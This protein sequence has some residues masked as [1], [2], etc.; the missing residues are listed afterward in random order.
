MLLPD[1]DSSGEGWE[2]EKFEYEEEEAKTDKTPNEDENVTIVEYERS[3]D[4]REEYGLLDEKIPQEQ[5]IGLEEGLPKLRE[6]I[7]KSSKI[8][9]LSGAG[10]STE[11]GIPA[12]RGNASFGL[13]NIWE[14][15]NSDIVNI[16]TFL[17]DEASR[18]ALWQMKSELFDIVSKCSPNPSHL[19]P[20]ELHKAG[21]LLA[22]LTQ[23]IDGLYQRAGLPSEKVVELHGSTCQ[24][25]CMKCKKLSSMEET[26]DRVK[27]GEAVPLC[28][29]EGCGGL[30]KPAT[31][32]FGQ[33]LEEEVINAARRYL[34]ECDLLVIMGTSLKVAP[35]N[36]LPTLCFDRNVP[37]VILNKDETMYDAYASVVISDAACGE[38]VG[39]IG[40]V[41]S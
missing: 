36:K 24:T 15:Y 14:R 41:H 23:N 29:V 40:Q 9:F 12:Y 10:V 5:F 8:V 11:S 4:Q 37:V 38:V 25:L 3:W 17:S 2:Y 32:F 1:M 39:K 21:K 30:I 35:V 20:A 6:L 27:K 7:A 16:S 19:V 28:L 33:P 26:L 18:V 13:F 34:K 31:I 22:V